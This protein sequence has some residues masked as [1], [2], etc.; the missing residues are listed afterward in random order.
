MAHAK[1][2]T[3]GVQLSTHA[4]LFHFCFFFCPFPRGGACFC[5]VFWSQVPTKHGGE[6]VFL[7]IFLPNTGGRT[8]SAKFFCETRGQ[9]GV[10]YVVPCFFAHVGFLAVSGGSRACTEEEA[11]DEEKEEAEDEE[12]KEKKKKKQKGKENEKQQEKKQEEK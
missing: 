9:M 2:D 3:S 12:G 6:R 8:S 1:V 4:F 5:P 10:K 11:E 7:Y